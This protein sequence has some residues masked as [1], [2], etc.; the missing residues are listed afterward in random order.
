M[1]HIPAFRPDRNHSNSGRDSGG[2]DFGTRPLFDRLVRMRVG[3]LIPG[4]W[5]LGFSLLLSIS[6]LAAQ[7][8]SVTEDPQ[9]KAVTQGKQRDT[10]A[11]PM[12]DKQRKRQADKL[13]KE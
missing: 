8:P 2:Y 13:R 10:V 9:A 5:L 3:M 1:V 11:K 4:K 12:T 7:V 6:T